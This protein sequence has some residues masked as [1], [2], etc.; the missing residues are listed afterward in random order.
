MHYLYEMRFDDNM[1]YVG[2]SHN[3]ENRIKE[4]IKNPTNK[5]IRN[6][7]DGLSY[8]EINYSIIDSF[9][10][11]D[12]ALM[13]ESKRILHHMKMGNSLNKKLS[14]NLFSNIRSDVSECKWIPVDEKTPKDFEEVLVCNVNKTEII[15]FSY[16]VNGGFLTVNGKRNL[17]N[18]PTHWKVKPKLPNK[19]YA[20]N[21]KKHE[22]E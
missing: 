8:D 21:N 18:E 5:T 11:R 7:L 19:Y 9:L 1:R 14:Y 10:F 12:G 17:T 20:E 13:A 22:V 6:R 16:F 15:G 3:V 2:I 4:H